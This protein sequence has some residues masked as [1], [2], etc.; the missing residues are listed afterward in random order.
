MKSATKTVSAGVFVDIARLAQ[1]AP[2]VPFVFIH[3]E[4]GWAMVIASS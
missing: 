2:I 4:C 3:V 1:P